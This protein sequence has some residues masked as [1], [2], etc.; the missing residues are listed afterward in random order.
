MSDY[1]VVV[2][3]SPPN[4][5]ARQDFDELVRR[6]TTKEIRS[7]GAILVGKQPDGEVVVTQ[8]GAHLG[9]KGMGWR[10]G[11]GVSG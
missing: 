5:T 11:V 9:R 2:A 6:I 1:E 8:T 10:G 3:G 7:E 4:G